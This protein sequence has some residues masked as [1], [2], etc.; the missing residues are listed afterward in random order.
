MSG[1]RR[2]RK[3]GCTEETYGTPGNEPQMDTYMQDSQPWSFSEFHLPPRQ[4]NR[5]KFMY[6]P[7]TSPT[8]LVHANQSLQDER[9]GD[10]TGAFMDNKVIKSEMS[11]DNSQLQNVPSTF[12]LPSRRKIRRELMFNPDNASTSTCANV[13]NDSSALS[14]DQPPIAN[15]AHPAHSG[16]NILPNNSSASSV[17]LL[18]LTDAAQPT[19]SEDGPWPTY[20]ISAHGYKKRKAPIPL[21]KPTDSNVVRHQHM[22]TTNLNFPPTGRHQRLLSLLMNHDERFGCIILVKQWGY[23]T[24]VVMRS[25]EH[26]MTLLILNSEDDDLRMEDTPHE[27]SRLSPRFFAMARELHGSIG[28]RVPQVVVVAARPAA[29]FFPEK[30]GVAEQARAHNLFTEGEE[31]PLAD[32]IVREGEALDCAPREADAWEHRR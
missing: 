23:K 27:P 9:H 22:R 17:N 19:H 1:S 30:L 21:E 29:L 11:M 6:V 14:V 15:E 5:R 28:E 3:A 12:H 31:M 32:I 24:I 26:T 7:H 20:L 18:P 2:K 13:P 25:F 4:K 8:P 16:G 10:Y